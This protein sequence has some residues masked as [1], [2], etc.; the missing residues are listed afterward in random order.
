VELCLDSSYAFIERS[1]IKHMG[2]INILLLNITLTISMFI[3]MHVY[4]HAVNLPLSE[5]NSIEIKLQT[6]TLKS[7]NFYYLKLVSIKES[8]LYGHSF[9]IAV[10]VELNKLSLH[11][12]NSILL[13]A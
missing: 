12:S 4:M 2:N 8:I 10:N 6:S 13:R 3:R 11:M 5:N 9:V 7:R 1:L